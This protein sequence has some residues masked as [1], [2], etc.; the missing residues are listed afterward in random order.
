MSGLG[1]RGSRLRRIARALEHPPVVPPF[2]VQV[3]DDERRAVGWYAQWERGG[4]AVYLG[5]SA[6]AAELFLRQNPPVPRETATVS[7]R[8]KKRSGG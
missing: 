2:Y 7:K 5:H 3:P 1:E 8:S 4:E 6:I